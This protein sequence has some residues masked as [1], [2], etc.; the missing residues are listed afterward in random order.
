MER[1]STT[2]EEWKSGWKVVL[3][4]AVG[5]SYFG[6]MIGSTGLFMEPLGREFGWSRTLLS[7]GNTISTVMH[8]ICSPFFG[9]LVDRYGTRRLALP[10]VVL[11]ILASCAFNFVNG[12]PVQWLLMWLFLGLASATIKSTIWN[13]AVAGVFDKGR[14][15]ALGLALTGTAV[16]SVVVPPLTNWLIAE[17][18]WRQA[19]LWLAIGWG[20]LTFL[21]CW[22][23][24]YDAHDR[25]AARGRTGE[26]AERDSRLDQPGLT[27]RQALRD[28]ALLRVAASTVI[29]ILLTMGLAVHLF[30]ILTGAG[31]SRGNA[32]WLMSLAGIAGIAG[33]LV[34]GLLLDRFRPNWIG[35]LTLGASALAFALLLDGIRSPTMIIIAMIVNG[36]S[37]GT[38][39]Q[40]CAFLTAAYGGTRHFGAIYGAM[41]TAVAAG[42]GLGPVFAGLVYDRIGGYEPFL[43]A[44]TVGSIIAGLLIFSLPPYPVWQVREMPDEAPCPPLIGPGTG[45]PTVDHRPVNVRCGAGRWARFRRHGK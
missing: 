9:L 37:A 39:M 3:A 25:A 43:V 13:A 4:A 26:P 14:G 12:S 17:F 31:V 32:A 18:G 21:V 7:L 28:S 10:G 11:T 45:A 41:A 23:C 44:G 42:S 15:L 34:S 2:A 29:V 30:P 27:L 38:K 22:L 5:F 40:I 16:T 36:Y 1:P 24:L 19:Y 8:G 6:V 20:G 33:K 35:A